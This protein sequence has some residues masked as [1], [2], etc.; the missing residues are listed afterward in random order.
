M[1]HGA[2][3][4]AALSPTILDGEGQGAGRE[5]Q[6]PKLPA[7]G[8]WAG[9]IMPRASLSSSVEWGHPGGLRNTWCSVSP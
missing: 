5:A 9:H 8:P 1:A 6:W 7:V 3:E 4:A 2:F